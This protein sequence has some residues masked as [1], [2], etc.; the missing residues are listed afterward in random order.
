MPAGRRSGAARVA[1]A[2]VLLLTIP[3]ASGP[4]WAGA[5]DVRFGV[6]VLEGDFGSDDGNRI[7]SVPLEAVLGGVRSRLSIAVPWVS[8]RRTG[9]VTLAAGGPVLLGTGGPGRPSYQT[10]SAGEARQGLGD[11]LVTDEI[12][13]SRGGQ[14]LKPL[15][16]LDLSLKVPTADERKGLGT[17]RR[18]WGAGIDYVQPLG[19]VV[20]VMLSGTRW[21]MG[22]PEGI[23]F[24]NHVD[25][26][27]GLAFVTSRLTVRALYE[28]H[29]AALAEVPLFDA[30][31]SVI[32]TARVADR[33][34]ARADLIFRSPQGGTTRIGIAKGLNSDSED[35]GA[36]LIFS[37]GGQ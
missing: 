18:D 21:V 26:S 6:Q 8:I 37:T 3:A 7:V 17:G 12:F 11:V 24:R 20:Q 13:L 30:S 33:K 2:L 28:Q 9:N 35:W 1:G 23:D 31:G 27:G 29:P 15:L 16:S 4:A 19:K 22:D 36:L 5:F 32:G 14:G 34:L 10:S 25:R